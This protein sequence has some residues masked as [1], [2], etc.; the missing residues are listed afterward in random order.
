MIRWFRSILLRTTW[1]FAIFFK[2][3]LI[4]I[5]TTGCT[6][7]LT[8]TIA[9]MDQCSMLKSALP[10]PFSYRQL[11]T[12]DRYSSTKENILSTQ[13]HLHGSTTIRN[14]TSNGD[15]SS[16]ELKISTNNKSNWLFKNIFRD[17]EEWLT[18]RKIMNEFL[19]KDY[20]WTEEILQATCDSFV[21]KIKRKANSE[22]A[23]GFENL[24]DELYLWSIYCNLS[25]LIWV[26]SYVWVPL[27]IS[28]ILNLMLGK[29]SANQSDRNFDANVWKFA[30]VAKGLMKSSAKLMSLP[31]SF[32]DKWNLKVWKEFESSAQES[33]ELCKDFDFNEFKSSHFNLFCFSS[34]PDFNIIERH[35]EFR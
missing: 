25:A 21:N 30:T 29:S 11:L 28:A 6:W 2:I 4:T 35:G 22:A 26:I 18:H 23:V 9:S 5:P 3:L 24:E 8:T 13:Y 14:T 1:I 12:S 33:I 20:H 16:C 10:M 34:Q 17:D 27:L 32:A 19:L 7:R 15:F 31:P